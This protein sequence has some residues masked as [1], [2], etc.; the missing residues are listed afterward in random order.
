MK[1]VIPFFMITFGR[2]NPFIQAQVV[3]SVNGFFVEED[4]TNMFGVGASMEESSWAL[5]TKELLYFGGG[6]TCTY[7]CKSICMVEDPGGSIFECWCFCQQVFGILR[8]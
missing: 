2:L 7:V 5:V 4:E 6:Y 8:F 1:E 3:V